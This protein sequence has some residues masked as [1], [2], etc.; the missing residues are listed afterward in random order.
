[1]D[2][3]VTGSCDPYCKIYLNQADNGV[4][5]SKT[6]KKSLNPEYYESFQFNITEEVGTDKF[7]KLGIQFWDEDMLHSGDDFIGTAELLLCNKFDGKAHKHN[8]EIFAEDKTDALGKVF[9]EIQYFKK[10]Q[11]VIDLKSKVGK[12]LVSIDSASKLKAMDNN[13]LKKNSS[14]PYVKL[15]LTSNSKAI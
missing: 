14:D 5:K 15:Y 13:L 9:I 2:L 12:V 3:G 7:L 11:P 8:L 1:M 10:D 4:F 6:V